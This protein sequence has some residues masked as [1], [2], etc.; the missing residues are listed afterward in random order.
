MY[1][2]MAWK[3]ITHLNIYFSDLYV[4]LRFLIK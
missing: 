4:Y 3:S 2:N 1:A